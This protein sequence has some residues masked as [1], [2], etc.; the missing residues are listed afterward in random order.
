VTGSSRSAAVAKSSESV[1][2]DH[3]LE[4]PA[5]RGRIHES[6]EAGDDSGAAQPPHP[7]SGGVGAQ[8]D[9]GSE[10][11]PGEPAVLAKQS[12]YLTV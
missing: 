5:A 4:P 6:G 3:R 7:I 8:T 1:L 9:G 10:V 2:P 11:A 12:E